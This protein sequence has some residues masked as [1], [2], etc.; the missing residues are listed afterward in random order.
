[1]EYH[2][3]WKYTSAYKPH[4]KSSSLHEKWMSELFQQTSSNV[5]AN[6]DS[7]QQISLK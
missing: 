2:W 5:W 1:M 3:I 4:Y 6:D 7:D